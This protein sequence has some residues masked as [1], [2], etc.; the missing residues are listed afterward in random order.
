MTFN[1]VIQA[2]LYILTTITGVTALAVALFGSAAALERWL[3]APILSTRDLRSPRP[4]RP[5]APPLIGLDTRPH[6]A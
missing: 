2:A 1:N 3:D 6:A 5:P 4:L